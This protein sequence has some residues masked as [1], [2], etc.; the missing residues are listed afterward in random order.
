VQ[1]RN[2]GRR[3]NWISMARAAA[4]F[5]HPAWGAVT[6]PLQSLQAEEKRHALEAGS[7]PQTS[8]VTSP[9]DLS[10][11]GGASS[12]VLSWEQWGN[13]GHVGPP[14]AVSIRYIA[15]L[16]T[17]LVMLALAAALLRW[18][19]VFIAIAAAL[20][21]FVGSLLSVAGGLTKSLAP[22]LNRPVEIRIWGEPLP[23]ACHGS[24]QIESIRALGAGL[25][26]F[27]SCGSG[28]PT[29]I[30]IAQ[31]GSVRI[32]E[33]RLEIGAAKYVQCAGRNLPRVAEAPAVSVTVTG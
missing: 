11:S 22:L 3:R 16:V 2:C 13:G 32:A 23:N 31:P 1:Q 4:V 7:L 21:L 20:L 6:D 30:K 33:R 10:A 28:S 14:S 26:L 19:I 29:H 12:P 25:H 27:V 9:P 5:W 8:K 17:A 18:S 15:L 24:C